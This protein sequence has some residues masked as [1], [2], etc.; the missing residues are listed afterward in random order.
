MD[1]RPAADRDA[2]VPQVLDRFLD[3]PVPVRS[4]LPGLTG[5]PATGADSSPGLWTFRLLIAEAVVAWAL[6]PARALAAEDVA[7]EGAGPLLVGDGKPRIR[8]ARMPS[9]SIEPERHRSWSVQARQASSTI[10][11]S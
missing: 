6:R 10:A 9:G 8:E 11:A 2:V 4:E 5:S 3:R 1:A 7:E